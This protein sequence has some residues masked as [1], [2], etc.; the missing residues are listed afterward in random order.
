V[1]IV[2]MPYNWGFKGLSTGPSTNYLTIDAGDPNTRIQE[3]KACLINI[4]KV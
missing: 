2:W 4:C 3:T 1:D